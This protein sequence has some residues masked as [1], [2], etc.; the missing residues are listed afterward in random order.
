MYRLFCYKCRSREQHTVHRLF[1]SPVNSDKQHLHV[2]LNYFFLK[3]KLEGR[4][5]QNSRHWPFSSISKC[6][7]SLLFPLY[8][9]LTSRQNSYEA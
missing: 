8:Y 4:K 6:L 5:T 1:S 7:L 3:K 2:L 9:I